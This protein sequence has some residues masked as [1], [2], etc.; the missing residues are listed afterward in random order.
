[1]TSSILN[2]LLSNS[3]KAKALIGV[4]K[5]EDGDDLFVGYIV[6]YNDVL[7]QLQQVTKYG[8]EDGVVILKIEDVETFEFEDDYIKA[9]QYLFENANKIKE[10]TVKS[11]KLPKGENWQY[12]VAKDLFETKKIVTIEV[13]NDSTVVNGYIIDF[14][15]THISFKPIDNIGKEEGTIIY[16]LVDVASFSI[17]EL[18]SRKRQTFNEWRK[19]A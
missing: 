17:D 3:K 4:R 18:E 11:L 8:L 12:E 5:Y 19:K 16:K 7:I 9:Y 1:M 2:T 6:D 13:S 15:E 10:Q 14:D